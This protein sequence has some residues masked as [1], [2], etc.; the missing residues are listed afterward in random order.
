MGW[1]KDMLGAIIV[2]ASV[3]LAG[4]RG[5]GEPEDADLDR[6]G[7]PEIICRY[8]P[9]SL[10]VWSP[11]GTMLPG[12]PQPVANAPGGAIDVWSSAA[13]GDL[14]DEPIEI[15]G[16]R[17]CVVLADRVVL[18][19]VARAFEPSGRLTPRHP[20]PEVHAALAEVY[21]AQGKKDEAERAREFLVL[22]SKPR[23]TSKYDLPAPR[24]GTVTQDVAKVV[25]E[26]KA[27][28]VEF[29]NDSGGIVH[30]V[31]G[32]MSFDAEKLVENIQAFIQTSKEYPIENR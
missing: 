24:A 16:C 17:S 12:W 8:D 4:C 23:P 5:E 28:K 20:A 2:L 30:A 21:D 7:T 29:R 9:N 14:D 10:G 18:R 3:S 32:R 6:D 15:P 19:A 13:V 31:V 22:T 11:A 26:Y 25:Q 27:G 1:L